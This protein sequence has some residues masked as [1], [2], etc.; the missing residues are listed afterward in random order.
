[1]YVDIRAY[2]R[3]CINRK[4]TQR[5]CNNLVNTF[6]LQTTKRPHASHRNSLYITFQVPISRSFSTRNCSIDLVQDI[7]ALIYLSS[8]NVSVRLCS[9]LLI[10]LFVA[11]TRRIGGRKGLVPGQLQWCHVARWQEN[12][13]RPDGSFLC[14]LY[15]PTLFLL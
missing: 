10:C 7:L 15:V 3:S 12:S 6:R 1:M 9:C 11:V 13:S 14:T 5:K 4:E 2:T 8:L